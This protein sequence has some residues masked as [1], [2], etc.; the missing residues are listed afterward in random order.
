[1]HC[2]SVAGKSRQR[3]LTLSESFCLAEDIV[4]LGCK[5]LTFI[6]GEIFLYE[7]WEKI[8][9]LLSSKGLF[10]NLMSNGFHFNKKHIEQIQFA[11]LSNVGISLD[12]TESIHNKIRRNSNSF[13]EIQNTFNLLN[14]AG[15]P[16]GVVTSLLELNY[17]YL[18]EIYSFLVQNNVNLWQI[19]LVNPM[20]NMSKHKD[21]VLDSKKIPTLIEFIK[22]KNRDRYMLVVAADNVGY[23][24]KNCEYYIR[25]NRSTVSYWAGCQAGLNTLFIDS[26][27]NVKGCGALYDE[28]F[29]E[30]NIREKSLSEI[31]E[32]ESN[33]EYN[34]KFN[35]N[36]LKGN[37]RK[38]EFG[39]IC[40]AGCRASNYFS[41]SSIYENA[42][43]PHAQ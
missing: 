4:R 37:C 15:I 14:E 35:Q 8:A 39:D 29:I 42:Y 26:I 38:C 17:P 3:E 10:V 12:G 2:G 27:G 34:R 31:W 32:D 41:T 20:G 30:G 36:M 25:G 19:Q 28:E 6:G 5:E 23:Y 1:M 11:N 9:Q 16:I 24:H 22:A 40:K 43:C 7:G 33:F 13:S 21:L 18:E